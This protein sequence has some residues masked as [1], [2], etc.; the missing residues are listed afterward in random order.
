MYMPPLNII[1]MGTPDFA[2]PSLKKLL[3][4]NH[5]V[6]A[7][8]TGVD[9]ERGRG[10]KI[11]FTPIKQFALENNLPILQ[12]EKLKDQIFITK[13]KEFNADLFI[14]VAFKILPKEV[15]MLPPKGSFNLHASLLP[16]FRGAAPIQ[17]AIISGEKETGVTT[18]ML[19]E[20]V[21]TGNIILQKKIF[22]N[23][24]DNFGSL[25][26]KLS[27]LGAETV[28]ETVNLIDSNNFKLVPQNPLL[29]SPAPK[30]TKE[31]M[32]I[33]WEKPAIEIHNLVRG[34]SPYPGAFFSFKDKIIK[35]FKTKLVLRSNL[36]PKQIEQSKKTLIIGCGKDAL[37]ILEL[38]LEGK[39]KLGIEEFLRGFSFL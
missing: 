27:I 4:S 29:A 3:E 12:P 1:F 21:D 26:N 7:V 17:W 10:Q 15:F 14:V 37:E 36:V 13:L 35:V 38:Q 28:L 19:D 20:K 23:E 34:L 25:H 31:L 8:V 16:K 22:I 33:D 39:K 9:K 24:D 5:K 6:V 11:S 32:Q 30:V 2:V 18:F